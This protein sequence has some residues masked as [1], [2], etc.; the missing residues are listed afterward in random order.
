MDIGIAV[1][2]GIEVL[3]A[4]IKIY[5]AFRDTEKNAPQQFRDLA[6]EVQVSLLN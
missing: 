4:S 6:Q 1:D 3:K 2:V 5:E